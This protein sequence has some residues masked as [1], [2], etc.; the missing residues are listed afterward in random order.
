MGEAYQRD[1]RSQN[2]ALDEHT[3]CPFL[4]D[5]VYERAWMEQRKQVRPPTPGPP[6][7]KTTVTF[8]SSN[9][10]LLRCKISLTLSM[11]A[12]IVSGFVNGGCAGVER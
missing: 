7:T 10:V 11:I 9:T 12:G 3:G 8:L 6:R 5:C 2:P 1:G 4:V